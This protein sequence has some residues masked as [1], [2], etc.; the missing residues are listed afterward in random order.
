MKKIFTNFIAFAALSVAFSSFTACNT[1]STANKGAIIQVAPDN[2]NIS[3]GNPETA[4]NG[5]YPPAPVAIMQADIKDLDGKTYKIEEKKGKVVLVNLWATWCGPC[6]SEM[7]H[8]VEMQNKYKDKN[9]EVLGLNADS[10]SLP[11]IKSFGEEM[12]LNY[13]LG[14]PDDKLISEM[15]RLSRQQGI[16]QSILINREGKTVGVFFGSGAKAINGMKEA[17]EKAVNL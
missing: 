17:V 4:K 12:K 6:R 15:M 8:L 1:A 9:F 11:A 16:P 7:P 2:V 5:D 13:A 10:E 3:S 14:V